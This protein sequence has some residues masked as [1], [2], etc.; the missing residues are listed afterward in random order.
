[1]MLNRS[2]RTEIQD[3][4]DLVEAERPHLVEYACYRL[5]NRDDAEDVVQHVRPIM[6]NICLL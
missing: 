1:M 6:K 5:G 2:K 4:D 3:I